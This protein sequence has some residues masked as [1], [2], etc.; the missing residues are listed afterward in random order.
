MTANLQNIK[1]ETVALDKSIKAA[2]AWWDAYGMYMQ[3]SLA[4]LRGPMRLSM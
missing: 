2:E 1:N 3:D 4:A